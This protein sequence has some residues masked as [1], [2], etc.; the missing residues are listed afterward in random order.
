MERVSEPEI[1][2]R[3]GSTPHSHGS[4]RRE[5]RCDTRARSA[6]RDEVRRGSVT[7]MNPRHAGALCTFV[8]C[9]ARVVGPHPLFG[10]RT[11][12]AFS[13][14]SLFAARITRSVITPTTPKKMQ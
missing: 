8:L 6:T 4:R 10:L 13:L 2:R 7:M 12:G 3:M 11:S 9:A 14:S 5:R 1:C